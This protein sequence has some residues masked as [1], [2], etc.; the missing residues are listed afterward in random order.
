MFRGFTDA[1]DTNPE[2]NAAYFLLLRDL[3]PEQRAARCLDL[4]A[5]VRQ[6]V[7]AGIQLRHPGSTPKEVLARYAAITLGE[8]VASR[9][10]GWTAGLGK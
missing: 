8:P 3:T 5:V 9:Y 6:A 1:S 2:M 7:I 4:S 10:F